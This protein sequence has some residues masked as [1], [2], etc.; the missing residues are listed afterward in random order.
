MN[1][2]VKKLSESRVEMSV[3]LPWEEWQGEIEHAMEGMAKSVKLPG[4]RPGK[5]P[6]NDE[7]R[8]QTGHH[9]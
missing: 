5:A 1:V 4:F 9:A 6:R 8:R 7:Q 2:T 3:V